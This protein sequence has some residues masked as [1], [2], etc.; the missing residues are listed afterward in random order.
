MKTCNVT[1]TMLIG[2]F[3]QWALRLALLSVIYRGFAK[4]VSRTVS[5]RFFFEKRTK[6]NGRKRKKTEENGK[7]QKEKEKTEENGKNGKKE[8]IGTRK[9]SKNGTKRKETEKKRKKTERKQGKT[10]KNGRKRKKNGKNRKRHRSGDPFC[11]TPTLAS[12]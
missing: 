2:S 8:K 3:C 5:P 12:V 9:N 10:E 11:E 6:K 1:C 7:K 4:G